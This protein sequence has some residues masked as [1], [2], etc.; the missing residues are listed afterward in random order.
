MVLSNGST[1]AGNFTYCEVEFKIASNASIGERTVALK[2]PN[3]TFGMDETV[4][5]LKVRKS[6][7]I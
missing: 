6:A 5:K 7:R 1:L 4:F 3:L 2:R